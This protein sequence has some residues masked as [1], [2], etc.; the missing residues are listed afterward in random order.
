MFRYSIGVLMAAAA[1]LL[2]ACNDSSS[3]SSGNG[4]TSISCDAN[5]SVTAGGNGVG[6]SG[7]EGLRYFR[8]GDELC[9]LDTGAGTS[10]S[11]ATNSESTMDL[12]VTDYER[13]GGTLSSPGVVFVADGHIWYADTAS[14]AGSVSPRQ[15]SSESDS[16]DIVEMVLAPDYQDASK[17]SLAYHKPGEGWFAVEVDQ[18]SSTD[19]VSFGDDHIPVGPYY[20]G[21][22]LTH[23]IVRDSS[24]S[25]LILVEVPDVA[26]ET[27]ELEEN[28][29]FV[30]YVGAVANSDALLAVGD[31]FM[32]LQEGGT[33][34]ELVA[35]TGNG[36]DAAGGLI[37]LGSITSTALT[38]DTS[39][40][41]GVQHDD[42]AVLLEADAVEGTVEVLFEDGNA[43]KSSP[44]LVTANDD[45]VIM[46]W[47][48]NLGQEGHSGVAIVPQ[49]GGNL[50][51]LLV[52]DDIIINSPVQ[53]RSGDWVYFNVT[54][55]S[56]EDSPEYSAR[57][58]NVTDTDDITTLDDAA[59]TG[60]TVNV[61][62]SRT[63]DYSVDATVDAV[64]LIQKQQGESEDKVLAY[65]A[66]DPEGGAVELGT[67]PGLTGPVAAIAPIQQLLGP[68]TGM[69]PGRLYVHGQGT[70]Q[71]LLYLDT[72]HSDSLVELIEADVDDAVINVQGG[73]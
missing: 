72:R 36:A 51:T 12:V 21:D 48:F 4:S 8:A 32:F 10:F 13:A 61:D 60:S 34:P 16:G 20:D 57:Y 42:N 28:V 65:D 44:V 14:A 52:S 73:F 15:V 67:I 24:D 43:G 64:L 33:D 66:L 22:Q 69:G 63:L 49:G 53:G 50:Q 45:S 59:W 2:V 17:G 62:S 55:V 1:T 41:L 5:V 7:Y 38:K 11:V 31:D 70:D 30:S 47:S 58:F 23:W 9:A 46:A 68:P 27:V 6:S 26:T 54:D 37:G 3:S 35:A 40:F 18:N 71:T 19:P 39:I 29:G 56:D 25:R